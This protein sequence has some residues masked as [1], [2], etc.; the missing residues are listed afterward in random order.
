MSTRTR[1]RRKPKP[2]PPKPSPWQRLGGAGKGI[3]SALTG[4]AAAVAAVI[5]TDEREVFGQ[6]LI[7]REELQVG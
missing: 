5:E 4:L 7:G 1:A 6:F 2:A 3:V